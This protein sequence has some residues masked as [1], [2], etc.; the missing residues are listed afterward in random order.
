MQTRFFF[1][2]VIALLVAGMIAPA[3]AQDETISLN[4]LGTYATGLFDE[5]A[6]EIVA[7]DPETQ[8]LFITNADADTLDILDISDPTVPSLVRTIELEPYGAGVNSVAIADGI[9]A[10]AVENEAVD[11]AGT[12]VFFDTAG[13][14][15]SQ[16]TVGVLPDMVTFT[17]DGQRVLTANEG[18][19][20]DDYSI[21]PE[22]SVSII[23]ISGG[24]ADLTQ[25][26]VSTATF[27]DFTIDD[28]DPAIRIFGPNATGAQD[29]EPEYVA[30]TPDSSTAYVVL[31]ENNALAVV[32]IETATVAALV[33]LGFKDHSIEGNGLDASNDDD[34]INIATYPVLGMYQPDAIAAFEVDGEVF[35]VTANEGD[36]RDYDTFSEEVD[37]ADLTLDEDAFP[38]AD[39]LLADA[40]MGPLTLTNTLGDDD[41]DG[42][43]ETLYAYGARSFSVWGAD[44]TLIFDS[45]D[46]FEQITAERLPEDFNSTNDENNSFDDRSD[47][48]GPEPE[49]LTVG[50]IDGALYVFVGLERIGGVMIYNIT[51]PTAPV[52]VD[53]VNNRDFAGNAEEGTAGDL[54]PEG[55]IF[56]TAEDSP[57]DAPL[58]VVTNEVSGTTSI[59]EITPGM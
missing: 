13:E 57:I 41:G 18:Q 48:K 16:V 5:G 7:H 55:L 35:L 42:A 15:I 36:A 8:V 3:A 46:Q 33:P 14:F 53:Y 34:A 24:V 52:F 27:T 28:I 45:G 17:P 4:L 39:A 12:V 20:S 38:N 1:A 59:Y 40:A 30:V 11:G 37:A 9:V 44:G 22:G 6:A 26:A 50:M 31:Q 25:D 47:N 32:D 21:D 2:I 49:G 23:D 29:L 54:G 56:I 10:A 58:L 19:P 51:D 43:F